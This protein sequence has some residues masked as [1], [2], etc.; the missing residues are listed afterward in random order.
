M[1]WSANFTSPIGDSIIDAEFKYAGS[2]SKEYDDDS[3]VALVAADKLIPNNSDTEQQVTLTGYR[4]GNS[5][6]IHV[7]VVTEKGDQ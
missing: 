7:V 5:R 2:Q 1:T 6:T 3:K 4:S